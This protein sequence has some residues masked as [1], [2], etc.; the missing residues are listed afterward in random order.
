M[1]K[2]AVFTPSH[3]IYTDTDVFP[4]RKYYYLRV[5]AVLELQTSAKAKHMLSSEVHHNPSAGMREHLYSV[6]V[7]SVAIAAGQKKAERRSLATNRTPTNAQ[8]A[9]A[10]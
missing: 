3:F 9:M 8:Q 7:L 1:T 10:S 5:A 4:S 2:T 6:C